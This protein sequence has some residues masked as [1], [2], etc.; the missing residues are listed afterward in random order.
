MVRHGKADWWKKDEEKREEQ[1]RKSISSNKKPQ[2]KAAVKLVAFRGWLR[3]AYA[4]DAFQIAIAT[5]IMLNFVVSIVVAQASPNPE[6]GKQPLVIDVLEKLFTSIFALE[7]IVNMFGHLG[8][9]FWQ[10]WWNVFD[11]LVV[12]SSI[13]SLFFDDM[14]GFTALRLLRAFRVFRLFKRVPALRTMIRGIME[15]VSGVT[16]AFVILFLVLGIWS[17]LGVSFFKDDFPEEFGSFSKALMTCFQMM[18]YDDWSGVARPVIEEK[19]GTA[20]IYFVSFLFA[21]SMIMSNI[22]VAI[23]LDRFLG[24]QQSDKN[25][26]RREKVDA[27]RAKASGS[28]EEE[29][30]EEE[31]E[32][33]EEEEAEEVPANAAR[34]PPQPLPKTPE[35][36]PPSLPTNDV[37]VTDITNTGTGEEAVKGEGQHVWGGIISRQSAGQSAGGVLSQ[38]AGGILNQSAGG[39]VVKCPICNFAS[40]YA[41]EVSGSI[42]DEVPEYLEEEKPVRDVHVKMNQSSSKILGGLARVDALLK[43]HMPESKEILQGMRQ[44]HEQ[45]KWL[46]W[47][48]VTGGDDDKTFLQRQCYT[49]YHTT[50]FQVAVAALIFINFFISIV[51]AEMNPLTPSQERTFGIFE[52]L[53]NIIFAVELLINME[54]HY[55]LPFWK[56]SWNVF[57]FFVVLTSLI[58]M[59]VSGLPGLSVLRLFRAFRAFRL[60]RR[61]PTLRK[62]I[63][64]VIATLP[65]V[66]TAFAILI[67]V[68]GIWSIIGVGFFADGFD[69]EFGDFFKAY[70]T[71]LQIMTFDAWAS[72]VARPVMNEYGVGYVVY[73]LSF[74]FI[75]SILMTNVIVAILL[76]RYVA[77]TSVSQMKS[78]DNH[79]A[80]LRVEKEIVSRLDA[81]EASLKANNLRYALPDI[82]PEDRALAINTAFEIC[83][84]LKLGANGIPEN[85]GAGSHNMLSGP[86]ATVRAKTAYD[87]GSRDQVATVRV[88]TA[89]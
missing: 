42:V 24:A 33:E 15:S 76:D 73:F 39:V 51:E 4:K 83:A 20:A 89:G 9:G 81:I 70:L 75:A 58:S 79:D 50:A 38:N 46:A 17:I 44:E 41:G 25:E 59:G 66:S 16:G 18:T 80:L 35:H 27:S 1:E 86:A 69:D 48:H 45:E 30:E 7:L 54:G 21:A 36:L 88:K 61:I 87:D 71:L 47:M 43:P 22:V 64:G 74:V 8:H 28:K 78:D 19:G 82:K 56:N 67:M 13:I 5:I 84:P 12:F 23:L 60:A 57:D 68:L 34:S 62:L 2:S 14:P 52:L 6:G 65:P 11:F 77:A 26:E 53:F 32:E 40:P 55:F 37:V 72:G 3:K 85:A 29:Q 63:V 10:S 49:L 31:D